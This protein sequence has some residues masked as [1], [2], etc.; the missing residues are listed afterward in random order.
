MRKSD[1]I[2]IFLLVVA[3][4]SVIHYLSRKKVDDQLTICRENEK[5]MATALELYSTDNFGRYPHDVSQMVPRYLKEIPV[6]PGADP[7]TA[8]Y[9]YR[10]TTC[11]DSFSIYCE[12]LN[13][14]PSIGTPNYPRYDDNSG[15]VESEA[16]S[17]H[18]N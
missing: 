3:I 10:G 15:F 14:Q 13:H 5:K 7:T 6:C 2:W 4:S 12:G 16:K 18:S 9:I 8:R 17:E 1:L 11:P